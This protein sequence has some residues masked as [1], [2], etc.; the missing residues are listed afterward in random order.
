MPES[1]GNTDDFFGISSLTPP[2]LTKGYANFDCKRVFA[3]LF[4]V[5]EL[6]Y[7]VIT[8]VIMTTERLDTL[9]NSNGL[10]CHTFA[11]ND[12]PRPTQQSLTDGCDIEFVDC[13][14]SLLANA[15]SQ[16]W[17]SMKLSESTQTQKQ[18]NPVDAFSTAIVYRLLELTGLDKDATLL[19][20]NKFNVPLIPLGELAGWS[21]PSPLG[22]G[23]HKE[24]GPWF[25]YRALIKT[26]KPLERN[27]LTAVSTPHT[28]A[29][30]SCINTPCVSACPASAVKLEKPFDIN[31]CANHRIQDN[32]TC[33][34]QCHARNACPV[35]ARYRY[36]EEQ[37]AYHMTHALD[38][39]IRWSS[40]MESSS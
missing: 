40:T 12:L 16:F 37:R 15:G 34:E 2:L 9:L 18:E 6:T 25:A 24:Y 38:A 5:I 31:R 20:P 23:L 21:T 27:S 8:R 39:L 22:L 26:T 32:T 19:Y 3:L 1:S 28:S 4:H 11:F 36:S 29:C 13:Y 33:K 10:L 14:L 30:L 35:G 17:T 7:L